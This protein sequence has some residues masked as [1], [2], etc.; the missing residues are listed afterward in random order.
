M[1]RGK[2]LNLNPA[3]YKSPL[4]FIIDSLLSTLGTEI[5]SPLKILLHN[6]NTVH[7]K[8]IHSTI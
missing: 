1:G 7:H 5:I 4:L 3:G 6:C 2:S 8:G